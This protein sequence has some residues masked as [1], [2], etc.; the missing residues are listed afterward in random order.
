M[1]LLDRFKSLIKIARVSSID[2]SDNKQFP[3]SQ[4]NY[5][6]ADLA[7]DSVNI[8]P[9]GY[10]ANPPRDTLGIIFEI[11]GDQYNTISFPIS[12]NTRVKGLKTGEVLIGN[13]SNNS[14]IKF[15]ESGQIEIKANSEV[16]VDAPSVTATATTVTINATS[17]HNGDITINGN[18]TVNGDISSSGS[19]SGGSVNQGGINLSTHTHNVTT[20]PGTTGPAQ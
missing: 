12:S 11:N 6:D 9:Y 3:Q 17:T 8:Y 18:V 20:A 15:N 1:N 5:F 4:Y 10:T 2:T 13:Y 14:T 19:I 7:A 16:V